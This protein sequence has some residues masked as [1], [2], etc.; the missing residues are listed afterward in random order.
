[1]FGCCKGLAVV[2]L[3]LFP[4]EAKLTCGAT[5][6]AIEQSKARVSNLK[7]AFRVRVI[8]IANSLPTYVA[9]SSCR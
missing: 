3:V 8:S 6:S 5:L 2:P 7:L 4:A 1:M 9:I